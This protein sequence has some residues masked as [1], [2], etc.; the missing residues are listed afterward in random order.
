M[1]QKSADWLVTGRH[2]E[3]KGRRQRAKL[4]NMEEV[5]NIKTGRQT[6]EYN[7]A[8]KL[9]LGWHKRQSGRVEVNGRE[10]TREQR[11]GEHVGV[12]GIR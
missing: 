7:K 9:K 2:Q 6:G 10:P 11:T 4:K 8:G 5:K 1:E 12:G 3:A